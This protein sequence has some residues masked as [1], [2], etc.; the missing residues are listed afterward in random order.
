MKFVGGILLIIGII[1]MG[2]AISLTGNF[3]IEDRY[4]QTRGFGML[5]FVLMIIGGFILIPK[6]P[7]DR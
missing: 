5:G 6:K 4:L 7:K 1:C 2:Y 3:E